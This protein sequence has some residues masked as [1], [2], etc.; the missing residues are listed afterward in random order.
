MAPNYD[1]LFTPFWYEKSGVAF[2]GLFRYLSNRTHG[3]LYFDLLPNDQLFKHFK[4][5]TLSKF[6]NNHSTKIQPYLL[7]LK[8]SSHA[9][10]F[11]NFENHFQLNQRWSGK[12]YARYISDPYFAKDFGSPYFTH[13]VNQIPSVAE[14]HY[15]GTHWKNTL[16]ATAY[17]TLHPIGQLPTP[18]H[19]QYQRA[20]ELNMNANYPRL[21]P[22]IHFNL[23]AQFVH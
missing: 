1:L 20:P 18:V 4:T 14:L 23:S 22:G 11:I 2:N 3:F 6:S 12:I 16:S 15:A 19:N 5:N 21:L 7:K 17:Q 10:G 9:R 8:D 13:D